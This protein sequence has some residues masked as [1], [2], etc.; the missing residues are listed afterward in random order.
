MLLLFVLE[1]G[2]ADNVDV[3]VAVGFQYMSSS[4]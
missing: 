4:I 2:L 1:D 3:L